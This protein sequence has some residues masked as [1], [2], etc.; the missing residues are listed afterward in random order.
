MHDCGKKVAEKL[1]I[2]DD[3]DFPMHVETKLG[4]VSLKVALGASMIRITVPRLV[5]GVESFGTLGDM[6]LGR[7]GG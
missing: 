1:R 3:G 7:H 2:L 5:W 6:N 4:T